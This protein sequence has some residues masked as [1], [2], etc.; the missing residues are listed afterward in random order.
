M[1]IE[2]NSI[3]PR[4]SDLYKQIRDGSLILKPPFQRNFVWTMRHQEE[5]ID[6]ILKG[7]PFPEVYICD[8]DIDTVTFNSTT[9]VIDG[10][11]RLTTIKR[12]I[13]GVD[14][15]N[16]NKTPEYKDLSKE[17]K[18]SFLGYKVVVRNIG[19]VEETTIREVFRRINLT[20]FSLDAIEIQNAIYD[21]EF[22]RTAKEILDSIKI[23]DYGVLKSSELDRMADLH[24]ILLIMSTIE[25]NGYFSQ[26]SELEDII[27]RYN[28]KYP[29]KEDMKKLLIM[30]FALVDEMKLPIDSVWFRK[31]NFFTM[32]VEISK[33][34]LDSAER[35]GIE[36]LE[37]HIPP[38]DS[39]RE[40]LNSFS[41]DLY[42]YKDSASPYKEY[43]PCMYQGTNNRK[44][45]VVRSETF[46]H[47]ILSEI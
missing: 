19:K 4:V 16:F 36:E 43:Y 6:T 15:E 25:N 26:D 45:R 40:L 28:E 33:F 38:I 1:K 12:Y 21:G 34:I 3:T 39:L 27:E 8:G 23:E 20:K 47:K 24:Y 29:R 18:E 37:K 41:K 44:S 30:V 46:R 5:F 31:S 14:T 35:T 42:L 17:Q 7:F 11:Q 2:T 13:E 32:L 9:L 22:I 10:Q